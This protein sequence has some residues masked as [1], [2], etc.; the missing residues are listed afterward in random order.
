MSICSEQTSN[1]CKINEIK[2]NNV[3]TKNYK[4]MKHLNVTAKN[5]EI[6]HKSEVL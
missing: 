3:E 6:M 5:R 2:V 4:S 1:V